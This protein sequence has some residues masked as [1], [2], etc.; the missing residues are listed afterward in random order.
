MKTV[1]LLTDFG[2][3]DSTYS[4]N[5][6]AE[7]QLGMLHRAGYEPRGVVDEGFQPRRNW[8]HS[9]LRYLPHVRKSNDVEFYDGW[10][11]SVATLRTSFE[12]V[13]DGVDVVITHDLIYQASML[14]H[15]MAA[16]RYAQ[17]HPDVRW[18]HW[19]HSA[20]PSPVW[21]GHD[22]R[23]EQVQSHFP[24]SLTVYPN[25]FDVP[26][27]ATNFHCEVDQVAVV[28][29]PTDACG[30]LGFQDITTR[31]VREKRLLE[32]DAILV[33][34]IRLDRGKQVEYV[35]RTAAAL[36]GIGRSVRVVVVDFHS[37]GGDKVVY[38]DWIKTLAVDLDLNSIE[39]TFTSEFDDSLHLNA[40]REMVRDLMLLCN[41]FVMPSV[42]ET[43]SLIAQEAGLCGAFLV[44]NRDFPPMRSVYGPDAAYYQF[45][46]GINA[47][48]GMD[49]VTTTKYDDVDDYFRSIAL[50]VAYELDHNVVLAQQRRIR[51]ERNP[52]Y[53]FKRFVEPLFSD[54]EG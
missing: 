10:E 44:L 5:I 20:T 6:I 27:V 3:P 53:I 12:E 46:S 32:A 19:V 35:L 33:Y 4:L 34:P 26:R 14:W 38:R 25:S 41:V 43:Y 50:R 8:Q 24:R 51:Q 37:T 45:S 16:R 47:L 22:P 18:L 21:M 49:G 17:D 11:E 40:P 54:W 9:D 36:K 39:V 48:T 13:L 42:S 29:H 31:L 7:E 1:S 52:D 28:P 15:N 2:A 23:L 30:Y